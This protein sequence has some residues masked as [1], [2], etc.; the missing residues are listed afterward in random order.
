[1]SEIT[2]ADVKKSNPRWSDEKCER[3]AAAENAAQAF[4][5]LVEG[6]PHQQAME[7]VMENAVTIALLPVP[8]QS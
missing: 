8:V 5:K 4:I 2:A 1:M 7:A 6:G 3:A